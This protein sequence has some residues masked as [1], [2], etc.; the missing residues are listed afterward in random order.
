M[1][2]P[3]LPT[4]R[5]LGSG[6]QALQLHRV[7]RGGASKIWDDHREALGVRSQLLIRLISSSPSPILEGPCVTALR[8]SAAGAPE[9]S[10]PPH[11]PCGL[12]KKKKTRR[13]EAEVAYMRSKPLRRS[14]GRKFALPLTESRPHTLHAL[15]RLKT[16]FDLVPAS[17]S[18]TT[19]PGCNSPYIGLGAR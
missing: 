13:H 9:R 16:G 1:L 11:S 19:V 15:A 4:E 8:K 10:V 12:T 14:Y 7:V 18:S 5:R 3:F 17:L 2:S 6:R